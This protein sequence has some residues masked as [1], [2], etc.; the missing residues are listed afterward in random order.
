M[1]TAARFIIGPAAGLVLFAAAVALGFGPGFLVLAACG[2]AGF[3]VVTPLVQFGL[4]R[5]SYFSVRPA[6]ATVSGISLVLGAIAFAIAS[7]KFFYW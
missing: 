6:L 3:L 2:A 5:T 4:E 7:G 1:P